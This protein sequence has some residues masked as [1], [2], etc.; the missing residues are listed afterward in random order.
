MMGSDDA[1]S[2]NAA[3]AEAYLEEMAQRANAGETEGAIH[4][5]SDEDWGDFADGLLDLCT[6]DRDLLEQW[7]P[8]ECEAYK[9]F[10][11]VDVVRRPEFG[12]ANLVLGCPDC[13]Y[14]FINATLWMDEDDLEVP[15]DAE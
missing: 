3:Q 14:T 9:E 6:E 8:R 4:I 2:Q 12:K 7:C 10:D 11:V 5:G 15:T 1:D 13:V